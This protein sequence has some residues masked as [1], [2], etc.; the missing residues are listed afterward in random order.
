MVVK[1]TQVRKSC[2]IGALKL[3]VMRVFFIRGLT[4]DPVAGG[5]CP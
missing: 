2:H 4:V 5:F 3:R 1:R